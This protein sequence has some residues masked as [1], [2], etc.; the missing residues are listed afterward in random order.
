MLIADESVSSSPSTTIA[1]VVIAVKAAITN[2]VL[3]VL[4]KDYILEFG[5]VYIGLQI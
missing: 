2:D 1:L 5:L 3:I 4:F